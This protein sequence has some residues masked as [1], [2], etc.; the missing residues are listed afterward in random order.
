MSQD[1][2]N[3]RVESLRVFARVSPQHKVMI[4]KAFKSHGHIVSMTGDG[5]NDA[6]SLKAADIGI[7]MG[8]TGTDVSKGAADMILTDDNFATIRLAI[9]EGRNI[10]NNIRETVLFL[11]SSNL[12]E[13]LTMFSAVICGLA[14]PLRAIHLLW[15]NL[16]TDSL[17]ALALGVDEPEDDLMKQPPRGAS[18]GLF[19]NGGL[20][21]TVMFGLIIG[22]LSLCAFLYEPISL[23]HEAGKAISLSNI[24][25][26]LSSEDILIRSQT[27]AFTT[28]G[29]SQLFNAIG[30]KKLGKSVFRT[31]HL[32]NKMMVVAFITG[33]VLQ[34]SVTEIPF[35]REAF[36]TAQLSLLEWVCLTLVCS[37]PLWCHELY[38]LMRRGK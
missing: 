27:F 2:L 16:I 24:D 9:R 4:V 1:E 26:I 28:L 6:P 31:N 25:N 33:F 22:L 20:F 7:A 21:A 29:I 11:L 5:V 13:I 10:Y 38:R 34:I 30:F 3:E 15:I 18:E 32:K 14:T 37:I 17:P 19:S 12:G 8:I 35:L 36:H 23:L